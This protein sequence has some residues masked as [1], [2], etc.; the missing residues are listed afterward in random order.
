MADMTETIC[1]LCLEPPVFPVVPVVHGEGLR[2]LTQGSTARRGLTSGAD[3][4]LD[5][6]KLCIPLPGT[7][8]VLL[9]ETDAMR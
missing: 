9:I 6:V 4:H 3:E 5:R 1:Q 7:P 2:A 8:N